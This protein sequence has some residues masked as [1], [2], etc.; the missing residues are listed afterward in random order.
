MITIRD[1]IWIAIFF[2]ATLVVLMLL[3]PVW[4]MQRSIIDNRI[5]EEI[6]AA[7]LFGW[8]VLFTVI[9]SLVY[10]VIMSTRQKKYTGVDILL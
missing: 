10:Y 4:I 1:I 9:I 3:R 5:T 7:K 8:T 2:V 6:S